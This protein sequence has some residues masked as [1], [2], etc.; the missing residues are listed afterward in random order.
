MP[1]NDP[2]L[3]P[4]QLKHLTL[5][6]RVMS[7]SHEPAYS[8]DGMPAE[9]Y[10]LYHEEK[11]KGGIALTMIGGSSIVTPDSPAAFGNLHIYKDEIVPWFGA[12]SEAVH[13][14]GCAVMCQITHLGRRTSWNTDDWLPVIS[15]SPI[16]EPAHR[17][18]P[19]EAEEFDIRRIVSAYGEAARRC[20]DGGLDGVEIEAYGHFADSFWSPATNRRQD[21][22]GGSLDNRMRVIVGILETIRE[23][24]GPDFIVGIRMVLDE[25]WDQGLS[26][27][28]G[29]EIA[30]RLVGADLVDFISVIR[31]HIETDE[32]LSHVIPGMGTPA[33]PHLEFAGEIKAELGVP[34]FHAARIND[35]AT[36]RHAIASGYLD[37]VGMT[38]AHMADPHIVA[39]IERGEEDRIRPCVGA[40][41][42]IDRIY[43]SGEAL[44]IH[45]PAT[46]RERDIPQVVSRSAN[47]SLK[48]VVV[49]AGPAGLEAARVSAERGHKVVLFEAQD[50][51]GGQVRLA[52]GLRRRRE[53][54]GIIDWRLHELEHHDVAM[55]FNALAEADDVQAEDP[56]IVIIATGGLPNSSF[57]A[58]GEDL[59]T[60]TWDILNRDVRPADDVLLFDD[61]GAHP[62]MSCAE[63]IA[64]SGAALEIVSPERVIA[65]DVGGI[66]YPAYFR[67][68]AKHQVRITLNE[69]LIGVRREGNKFVAEL[70]NEYAKTMS[71]RHVDQIVVEH[72]SLPVD[73]LYF[74]LVGGSVNGGEID[75]DALIACKPQQLTANP[76]GKFRLYR[77]GD[78]VA[79]RNIHAAIYDAIRLCHVF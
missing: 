3:Q 46:G 42:C 44:C 79:S 66:N 5:K 55:R 12:L 60:T 25:N 53:I 16:R 43:E 76:T 34:V 77:I 54:M 62:G 18:F 11:A 15:A 7:T 35:I 29:T 37:M 36:A 14:H 24:V 2:L 78:A 17:A 65:P 68:F 47:P 30:R 56:D 33:A 61:N 57:L 20:R 70:F 63:L 31:G 75:I 9:R 67:A 10:R 74:D 28:E 6:N 32:A 26:R 71:K 19:K 22:Y 51:A 21:G 73:E 1:A 40:G 13:A 4:F 48:V 52:A 59:V 69:R 72:G 50:E 23:K 49:G 27:D 8:E 39:K 64:E 41:Y 45:N 38:R 58:R